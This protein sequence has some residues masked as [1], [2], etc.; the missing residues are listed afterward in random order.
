LSP[1]DNFRVPTTGSGGWRDLRD[2][3]GLILRTLAASAGDGPSD[4]VFVLGG[5]QEDRVN[6]SAQQSRALNLVWALKQ[7]GR[8]SADHNRPTRVVVIG[9]GV[10]GATFA[11]AAVREGAQVLL[12]D[13]HEEPVTV[14]RAAT[15]RY[16]HPCLFDWPTDGWRNRTADTP[17]LNWTA[18]VGANVRNQLVAGLMIALWDLEDRPLIWLPQCSVLAVDPK[19]ESHVG[20]ELVAIDEFT[21][22]QTDV[23]RLPACRISADLVVIATG[24]LPERRI[25]DTVSG[26]YWKNDR[27][28]ELARDILIIGDGD[29]GLTEFFRLALKGAQNE[30]LWHQSLLPAIVESASDEL[31]ASLRDI[32]G[33][34]RNDLSAGSLRKLVADG[35]LAALD[36]ELHLRDDRT[37][38]LLAGAPL[39]RSNSFLINRFLAARIEA[40]K[41]RARLQP[42]RIEATDVS[43][44]AEDHDVVWRAGPPPGKQL[45]EPFFSLKGIVGAI[46]QNVLQ[47]RRAGLAADVLDETRTPWWTGQLIPARFAASNVLKELDAL[48]GQFPS[49]TSEPPI[50]SLDSEERGVGSFYMGDFPLERT[51]GGVTPSMP[52]HIRR[53]VATARHL[54]ALAA[55]MKQDFWWFK[56]DH[57]A[58]LISLDLLAIACDIRPFALATAIAT[59]RKHRLQLVR[60]IPSYAE[61]ERVW[62]AVDEPADLDTG[63][64]PGVADTAAVIHAPPTWEDFRQGPDAAEGAGPILAATSAY[65]GVSLAL[66]MDVDA[67]AKEFGELQAAELGESLARSWPAPRDLVLRLLAMLTR[68]HVTDLRR[69]YVYEERFARVAVDLFTRAIRESRWA[70]CSPG[71]A[72]LRPVRRAVTRPRGGWAA[73]RPGVGHR[74]G[75]TDAQGRPTDQSGRA[76]RNAYVHSVR[77]TPA[78]RSRGGREERV[79]RSGAVDLGRHSCDCHSG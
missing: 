54:Y 16:L 64:S 19:P 34:I 15:Q 33:R 10:A 1:G 47:A 25:P 6:L 14:Q 62:V 17:V 23:S 51:T 58:G 32:E 37:V 29:G 71:L 45:A 5:L 77:R 78:H 56:P 57:G 11:A 31:K 38:T 22:S 2:R 79:S 35:V 61:Q 4:R 74:L 49:R 36:D 44:L 60:V 70:A 72:A 28:A 30:A 52:D 42:R 7:R 27:L 26:T 3:P 46:G 69:E 41:G 13:E 53:I 68:P 8:L 59:D 65:E 20:V 63:W 39:L 73:P 76:G 50:P 12:I 75:R 66:G 21:N 48:R 43:V 24:F 9:A 18:A 55:R 67:Q 40:Q